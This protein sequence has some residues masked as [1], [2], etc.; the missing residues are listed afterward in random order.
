V[1]ESVVKNCGSPFHDEVMNKAFMEELMKL[2]KTTQHVNIREKTL[3]LIQC[4]AHAFRH[5]PSYKAIQDVLNIMKADGVKFPPLVEADA[6]LVVNKAPPLRVSDRCHRCNLVFFPDRRFYCKA[7]GQAFCSKCS[8][9]KTT[10][11][12]FG[13]EEKVRVCDACYRKYGM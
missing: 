2:A 13:I 7:C 11:P 6:I 3:E 9:K 1:L 12:R 4:W 10:L 8:D 5:I